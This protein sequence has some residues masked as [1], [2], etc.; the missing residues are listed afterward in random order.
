M[1]LRIVCDLLPIE[2]QLLLEPALLFGRFHSR[3]ESIELGTM[4]KPLQRRD[5]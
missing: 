1:R 3:A 4:R 5:A 2:R